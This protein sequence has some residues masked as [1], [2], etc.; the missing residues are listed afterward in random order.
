MTNERSSHWENVYAT[1]DSSQVS[2]FEESPA[3]SMELIADA[4]D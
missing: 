2:W 1:K 3:L 4:Y